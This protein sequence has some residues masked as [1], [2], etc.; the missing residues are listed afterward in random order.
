MFII[1][2]AVRLLP[3][4]ETLKNEVKQAFE[5]YVEA[6]EPILEVYFPVPVPVPVPAF[7]LIPGIQSRASLGQDRAHS[8]RRRKKAETERGHCSQIQLE[9]VQRSQEG[10]GPQQP[11]L[12]WDLRVS[13]Q[14]KTK[15]EEKKH[16]YLQQEKKHILLLLSSLFVFFLLKDRTF[17]FLLFAI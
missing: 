8:R 2:I 7:F 12:S 4:D 3:K 1:C 9:G 16:P 14:L 15:K 6:I 13:P 10:V 5:R 17:C 11:V